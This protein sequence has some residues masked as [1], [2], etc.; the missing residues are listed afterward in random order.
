MIMDEF[1]K[2]LLCDERS[3]LIP[4]EEDLYGGLIGEWDF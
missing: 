3:P 4:E 1:V 2:A